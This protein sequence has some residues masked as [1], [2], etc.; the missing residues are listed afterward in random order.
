M[1]APA[2]TDVLTCSS[3]SFEF[4][5]SPAGL[6]QWPHREIS[7]PQRLHLGNKAALKLVIDISG[8][9][10]TFCRNAR[11]TTVYRPRLDRRRN[12]L[13]Q[14]RR[15][16]HDE[17]I[18][19]AQFEHSF[20]ICLPAM[21]ATLRPAGS[22]PVSVAATTRRSSRMR[23][24]P[25]EPTSRVWKRAYGNPARRKM[26]SMASAHCGTFEACL[27]SPTLPAI[28]AGAAKRRLARTENSRASRPALA[29]GFKAYVTLFRI[30]LDQ[31]V[32]QM[33]P[34]GFRIITTNPGAL[35]YLTHGT[36][37]RFTHFPPSLAA[38]NR[39][40][41]FPVSR[42]RASSLTRVP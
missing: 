40:S 16:H 29:R 28:S 31:L 36:F 6:Y 7:H 20:L 42:L 33:L 38:R 2:A 21:P 32:G 3:T 4:A 13:L 41:L 37:N 11:L 10:E 19:A 9:Y 15:R 25:S 26:S 18:A 5:Q 35:F 39:S 23:W 1:C 30:R 24:T 14:I 22:L 34:A 27:S 17:W 12:S 8:N